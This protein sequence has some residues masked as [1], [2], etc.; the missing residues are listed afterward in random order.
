MSDSVGELSECSPALR[1][2]GPGIT[3]LRGAGLTLHRQ[4]Q[5]SQA[6]TSVHGLRATAGDHGLTQRCEV[7][8]GVHVP[9][10]GEPA[11]RAD[12]RTLRQGSVVFSRRGCAWIL[13][14][15]ASTRSASL[16]LGWLTL[17]FRS[18]AIGEFLNIP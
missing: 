3:R 11:L 14:A 8:C 15:R 5:N 4:G 16:R 2:D 17:R 12:V 1:L 6:S 7:P 18:V 9:V 10:R 13:T